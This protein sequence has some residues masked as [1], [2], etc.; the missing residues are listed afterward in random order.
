MRAL[1]TIGAMLIPLAGLLFFF[2]L[3]ARIDSQEELSYIR[4]MDVVIGLMLA[5]SFALAREP[6]P[7]RRRVTMSVAL[8][9]WLLASGLLLLWHELQ[10]HLRT[11]AAAYGITRGRIVQTREALTTYSK[12]CGE[13][14]SA[15]LG[16]NA[17]RENPGLAQWRGPYTPDEGSICDSW[18]RRLRYRLHDNRPVV[19]SCGKDGISGTRDDITVNE[20]GDAIKSHEKSD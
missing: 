8:V 6:K 20:G 17:L 2:A 1:T 15:T 3:M 12:D 11:S 18:G 7:V 10:V 4:V 9:I 19:W 5:A 16:L 14:P 13:F